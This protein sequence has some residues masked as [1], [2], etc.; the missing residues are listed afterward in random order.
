MSAGITRNR[1][2]ETLHTGV[3]VVKG[4]FRFNTA[5]DPT[6]IIGRGIS[7]VAHSATGVWTVTLDSEFQNAVGLESV[8]ATLELDAAAN[9]HLQTG[10]FTASAG[11][12]VVRAHTGGSL[13]DIAAGSNNG[14]WC[15]LVIA[16]KM[17]GAED[18]S[19]L[20]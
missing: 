5:S 15:H 10:A 11:T 9:T 8:V 2:E 3:V 7:S 19:G 13:A 6:S 14:N 4:R 17:S 18:G 12:L 20:V 16:L 1:N